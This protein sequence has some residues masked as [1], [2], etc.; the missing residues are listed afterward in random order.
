MT[1]QQFIRAMYPIVTGYD[2]LAQYEDKRETTP[3]RVYEKVNS[4]VISSSYTPT[5]SRHTRRK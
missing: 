5:S 4:S 3:R 1:K 2:D